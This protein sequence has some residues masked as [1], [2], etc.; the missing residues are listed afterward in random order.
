MTTILDWAKESG[1]RASCL[2]VP[3]SVRTIPLTNAVP[4]VVFSKGKPILIIHGF[5][6]SG[7][8]P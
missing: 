1:V 3:Y 4:I 7:D 6:R 2:P 5:N 8:S